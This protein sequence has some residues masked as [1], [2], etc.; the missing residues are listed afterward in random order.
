MVSFYC[1]P[2]T[3]MQHPKHDVLNAAYMYYY[4]SDVV[5]SAG[6]S[7]EDSDQHKV[8]VEERLNALIRDLMVMAQTV[9]VRQ[10]DQADSRTALTFSTR[11]P[12]W[13]TTCSLTSNR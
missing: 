13:T 6:G 3:I 5:F 10:F 9:S 7:G 1:L 11:S 4:A 2:S 8:K 12:S